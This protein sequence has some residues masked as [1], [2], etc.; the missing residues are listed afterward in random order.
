[1]RRPRGNRSCSSVAPSSTMRSKTLSTAPSGSALGRSILFTTTTMRSPRSS[2]W[3]STK[4]VWGLGPSYASTM[5]SAPSAM[6]STRS[7][8]PPKSAWPGVDDVDL[9]VFIGD[10]DVFGQN[11]D[12]A[13]TL[14]VV[15]IEHALL[16]ALILAKHMRRPQQTVH[17]R[18]LAVVN[19][20]DDRNV[21]EI[22]LLHVVL[23]PDL[24]ENNDA[25][26]QSASESRS[27][28]VGYLLLGLLVYGNTSPIIHRR[29]LRQR[30]AKNAIE[31]TRTTRSPQLPVT[32]YRQRPHAARAGAKYSMSK[33]A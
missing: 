27:L 20:S 15:G 2:A 12:A 9:H 7:T 13:L 3:D 11:G 5:S 18:G 19:V 31:S 10:R 22:L 25:S 29:L 26:G 8:S 28:H 16:D 14:L 21:A 6:F 33:S 24:F 17:E 4:R 32:R 30:G 23:F 1:M